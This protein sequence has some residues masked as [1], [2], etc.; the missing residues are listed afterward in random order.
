[1]AGGFS[2][3]VSMIARREGKSVGNLLF[4]RLI[5]T[6][7]LT[8]PGFIIV[9]LFPIYPDV[10]YGWWGGIWQGF[11]ALCNMAIHLFLPDTLYYAPQSTQAYKVLWWIFFIYSAVLLPNIFLINIIRLREQSNFNFINPGEGVIFGEGV[12]SDAGGSREKSSIKNRTIKVFIS[13]TFSDMQQERDYLMTRIFPQLQVIADRRNVRIIPIDLRWG[14]TEEEAS[15]GKVL[16]LCLQE[17]DNSI[18]FFIGILGYR[19][20]WKPSVEEFYKSELIQDNYPWVKDDIIKGLSITEIEFQY[21]VLRRKERINAMFFSKSDSSDMSLSFGKSDKAKISSL[22]REILFD[23]RY[24]LIDAVN[25]EEIGLRVLNIFKQYLDRYFPVDSN[26]VSNEKIEILSDNDVERRIVNFFG[27]F[28]KRLSPR[29][30]EAIISHPLSHVPA[31]LSSLLNEL[32]IFGKFEQLDD[33]L[34]YWLE[35]SSPLEFYWKVLEKAEGKYGKRPVRNFFALLRVAG[36]DG[37]DIEKVLK[38]ADV[39]IE[40]R[41]FAVEFSLIKALNFFKGF[42]KSLSRQPFHYYFSDYVVLNPE[43]N[44]RL[45]HPY[46]EQAV[47]SRYLPDR[48]ALKKYRDCLE[49]DL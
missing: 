44:A 9:M 32:L 23:G 29:Q 37:Y 25:A 17:I 20:G 6:L 35:A 38:K 26:S 41:P 14:I 43:G 19:Y 49:S 4:R 3:T 36:P 21:G 22:K 18:P 24:P 46:M 47:D 5:D 39:P 12:N 28:G 48:R 34:A 1:M 15:T 13:S 16:E 11:L 45:S 7:S 2:K 30:L 10:T 40:G 27:R 42:S 8:I 33:Y 31:V